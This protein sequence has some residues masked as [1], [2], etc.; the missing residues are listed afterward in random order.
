MDALGLT[1]EMVVVLAVLGVTIAL[2]VSEIVR[3]DV[4]AVCVMVSLGLLTAVPGLEN[5][6]DTRQRDRLRLVVESVRAAGQLVVG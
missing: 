1:F 6:V 3:V 2:F 5:L 4:A